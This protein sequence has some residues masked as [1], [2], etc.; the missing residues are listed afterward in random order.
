MDTTNAVDALIRALIVSS[1]VQEVVPESN[2]IQIV[3][4]ILAAVTPVLSALAIYLV[5]LTAAKVEKAR[6][7]LTEFKE[8]VNGKMGELLKVTAKAAHAEGVSEHRSTVALVEAAH[9]KGVMEQ[10]EQSKSTGATHQ[11]V[12]QQVV[13]QHVEDQTVEKQT[14]LR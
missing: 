12:E 11:V 7:E 8:T 1:R 9:A 3:T 10:M 4:L 5:K 6:N 2:S 14:K 13:E